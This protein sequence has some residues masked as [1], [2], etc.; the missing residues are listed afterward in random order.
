[1]LFGSLQKETGIIKTKIL[2]WLYGKY[3]NRLLAGDG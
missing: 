2:R 3:D 1:M